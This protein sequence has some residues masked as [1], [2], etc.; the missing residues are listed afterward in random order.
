M[1]DF[2]YTYSRKQAIEDGVL[3]D[4]TPMAK[5]AGF[6]VPVA[7]TSSFYNGYIVPTDD[8]KD[9]GQSIEGRLWDML[10][11]LYFSSGESSNSILNLTMS[12]LFENGRKEISF[13][14]VIGAGDTPEPVLTIM[15]PNED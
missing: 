6:K 7:I 2:V 5:E 15:L 1:E 13:K 12:I 11:I 14:A 8:E 10:M 4:I 3:V 9:F